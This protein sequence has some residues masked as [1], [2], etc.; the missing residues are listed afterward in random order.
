MNY[1]PNRVIVYVD[2]MNTYTRYEHSTA[3]SDLYIWCRWNVHEWKLWWW[4]DTWVCLT[5]TIDGY[6]HYSRHKMYRE[7]YCCYN[8]FHQWT[9]KPGQQQVFLFLCCWFVVKS[10]SREMEAV[11]IVT[12]A[13]QKLRKRKTKSYDY[14][15]PR[16]LFS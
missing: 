1:Q 12:T 7:F 5:L 9:N 8:Y 4:S 14:Y 13:S 2:E 3:H 11:M 16:F 15:L 6:K 10:T